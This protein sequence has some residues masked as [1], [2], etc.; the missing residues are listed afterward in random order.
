MF[1]HRDMI[2]PRMIFDVDGSA[3]SEV[4]ASNNSLHMQ[5]VSRWQWLLQETAVCWRPRRPQRPNRR[6]TSPVKTRA[7]CLLAAALRE[8]LLLLLFPLSS[9]FPPAP[10]LA[11]PLPPLFL[12]SPPSAL[13]LLPLPLLFS[14]LLFSSSPHPCLP[15]PSP[16]SL[17]PSFLSFLVLLCPFPFF[18]LA[19]S[20]LLYLPV[21]RLSASLRLPSL[22]LCPSAA[23]LSNQPQRL[24]G[25]AARTASSSWSGPVPT[26]LL[27]PNGFGLDTSPPNLGCIMYT[28]V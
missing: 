10:P 19:P 18:F 12:L 20:P 22:F 28:S 16:L 13:P 23:A 17:C 7:A 14:L 21:P 9:S 8:L 24:A 6:T 26:P 15:L 2:C 1:R 4:G 11:P 3:L 27:A 5:G 25:N